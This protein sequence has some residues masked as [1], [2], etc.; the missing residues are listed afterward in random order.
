MI[1][2][3]S[4]GALAMPAILRSPL[5]FTGPQANILT[6]LLPDL[7]AGLEVVS[8]ELVGIIPVITR[9]ANMERAALNQDVTYPISPLM[10]THD[11]TP[12]MSVPE[13]EDHEVGVGK[14]RITKSKNVNFGFVGEEQRA[15]SAGIGTL[16]LQA[17]FFAQGLRTLVNEM[18]ADLFSAA[19]VAASRAWGTPGTTPL[20]SGTGDAAQLRRI[21]NDNGAPN[22]RAL[23]INSATAAAYLSNPQF[24][25][26][27][28]AGT[29]MGL[30]DGQIGDLA[31]FS[32]HETGASIT[33]VKGTGAAY[34]TST[35]GYPIGATSIALITG[36][37]TVKAG[38]VI[39][40][41][42]DTNKYVV[43]AGIAA[44][45]TIRIGAPGLRQ[46]IPAAATAVT[47][48]NT[49]D[50]N[51]A[52][53]SSA[54]VLAAR[55]PAMPV[56]GDLAVDSYLLTD[57]RSGITFDVRVYLGFGKVRYQVGL[58]WGWGVTNAEHIAL[59]RG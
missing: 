44:P 36:A 6:G 14:V 34:T 23:I 10:K 33:H 52:M 3:A 39:A 16:S 41:A 48:E 59:L 4:L 9:S 45:G 47:V 1:R 17:S 25:K 29:D 53:S 27:N 50:V 43:A 31:G 32:I 15:L 54:M 2:A 35:A 8:R 22:P 11:N 55:A 42:G 28:E 5:M 49:Y 18:E 21:L 58:A 7:M 26:T 51:V 57:A 37:G 24:T 13:P 20:L 19:Y 56:E 12:A 46:A 30:R 40:I 38:D